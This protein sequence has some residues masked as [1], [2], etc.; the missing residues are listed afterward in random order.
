MVEDKLHMRHLLLASLGWRAAAVVLLVA[1][2]FF[3]RD[4]DTS[5]VLLRDTLATP[6]GAA[7]W[8]TLAA[9]FC[10]WD[11][12]YFVSAAKDG[13]AYEQMLAFQPG[14]VGVLRI[15]GSLTAPWSATTA[16]LGAMLLANAASTLSPL[17]L[18]MLTRRYASEKFAYTA[19]MLSVFAPASMSALSSPTPEPFFSFFSLVGMLLLDGSAVRDLLAATAFAAATLFRANGVLL[20]G[21]VVW[22]VYIQRASAPWAAL[23]VAVCV[24]PFVAFQAW[25]YG[26]LCPG[27]PWCTDAVPLV[28]PYVQR[29]YWCVYC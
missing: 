27:Q 1:T 14:I 7:L 20:C 26:R 9:P 5:A 6:D 10:R 29:V 13:Y 25:A 18:Y 15:A 22:Q 8:D 16:V 17:L 21:Y 28:Y 19:A 4:F 23:L 2:R 24:A 11:T 12:L 3:Q